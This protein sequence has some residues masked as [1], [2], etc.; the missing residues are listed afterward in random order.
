MFI[1]V[2]QEYAFN[3]LQNSDEQWIQE[4]HYF[5]DENFLIICCTYA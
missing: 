1:D 2:Q 5:N 3:H 4:I